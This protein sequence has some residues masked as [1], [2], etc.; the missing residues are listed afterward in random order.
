MRPATVEGSPK[1]PLPII[2]LTTSATRLP[3]PDGADEFVAWPW[4]RRVGEG[5]FRTSSY[6]HKP[7]V[8]EDTS[9]MAAVF[10]D[11]GAGDG[12]CLI[13]QKPCQPRILAPRSAGH[14]ELDQSNCLNYESA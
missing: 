12:P 2:E 11:D 13:R 14:E 10:A 4:L 8:K 1:M 9:R 3:A 5:R 6:Y 7:A